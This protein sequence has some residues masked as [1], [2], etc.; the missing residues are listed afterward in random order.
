VLHILDALQV[1]R[2]RERGGV[3]EARR[4]SF[5]A[6][7]V[8]QIGHVYEGLLDHAA[9]EATDPAVGLEG[10]LEPEIPLDRMDCPAP[11]S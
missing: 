7:D 4:L 1:L 10:K 11:R 8:E 3:T 5:R 6:L 9:I 2:F